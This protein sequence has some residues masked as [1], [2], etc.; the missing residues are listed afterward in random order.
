MF[1]IKKSKIDGCLEIFSRVQK[2]NRG[3]FVKV[4][5]KPAFQKLGIESEF[6]EEYYSQSFK[7]VIRGLHF[8]LPPKDH[9]KIIFCINGSVL[10]VVVDLRKE[11]PTY[12]KHHSFELNAKQANMIYIPKGMAH[13]F[14]SISESS[15]LVYKTSTVYDPKY[16][17]GILWNSLDINWPTN[18]PIMSDRDKDFLDFSLF[19]SPFI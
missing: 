19:K 12:G 17:S 15:T 3:S 10:D 9:D 14:C 5:H 18:D 8:Q 1:Q 4:F 6:E 7:N 16:D 11:S 13:G 2:D